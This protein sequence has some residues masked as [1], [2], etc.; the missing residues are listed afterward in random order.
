MCDDVSLKNLYAKPVGDH[1]DMSFRA[2]VQYNVGIDGYTVAVC[3]ENPYENS[4]SFLT[5]IE[6]TKFSK[7]ELVPR[8]TVELFG[9]DFGGERAREFLQAMMNAAWEIGIRPSSAQDQRNEL[10]AVRYHL[11]DMR[12]IALG[13]MKPV[14]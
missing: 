13:S 6:F 8:E 1:T 10:A 9:G 2:F 5:S 12:K 11:E 7:G 14:G 3:E 4:R